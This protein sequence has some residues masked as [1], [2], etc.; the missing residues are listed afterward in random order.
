MPFTDLFRAPAAPVASAQ[1]IEARIASATATAFAAGQA[2]AR[3]EAAEARAAQTAAHNHALKSV[4]ARAASTESALRAASEQA[5]E[6]LEKAYAQ[7]LAL[8]AIA[9][10]R[11][12]IAAEPALSA[13]TLQSLLHEALSA[14]PEG[15]AGTLLLPPGAPQPAI[16]AGWGIAED[17]SLAPGTLRARVDATVVTASLERRFAQLA[18]ELG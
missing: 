16:P 15:A 2:A 10:A 14:L 11:T 8:V 9:I 3:V 17:A 6:A 4:E 18:G 12:I 7:S 13:E 5:F 1:S